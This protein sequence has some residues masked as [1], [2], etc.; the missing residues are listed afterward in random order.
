MLLYF[1][2]LNRDVDEVNLVLC[3]CRQRSDKIKFDY[4]AEAESLA[5]LLNNILEK[6]A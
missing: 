6:T 4:Q 1:W 2:V 5:R 3:E